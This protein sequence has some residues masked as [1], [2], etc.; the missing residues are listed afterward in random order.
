MKR[1]MIFLSIALVVLV[2]SIYSSKDAE[3]G[4]ILGQVVI[5]GITSD[6]DTITVSLPM[7]FINGG[8]IVGLDSLFAAWA[9]LDTV[10]VD[11]LWIRDNAY[12]GGFLDV[13]SITAR[14]ILTDTLIVTKFFHD[15]GVA[16]L[17]T[18]LALP[19]YTSLDTLYLNDG[20]NGYIWSVIEKTTKSVLGGLDTTLHLTVNKST[21]QDTMWFNGGVIELPEGTTRVGTGA[22]D[23]VVFGGRVAVGDSVTR[24]IMQVG[25]HDDQFEGTFALHADFDSD[26]SDTTHG[27][28]AIVPVTNAT[29]ASA[30]WKIYTVEG[31]GRIYVD[32]DIY[33]NN[34]GSDGS[35]SD[36][37]LKYI[38]TV[39]SNVQTQIDNVVAHG[40]STFDKVTTDT[41]VA[42]YI[43]TDTLVAEYT[44]ID[45][46]GNGGG[47]TFLD[48]STVDWATGVFTMG[49]D[50]TDTTIFTGPVGFGIKPKRQVHIANSAFA[51][52]LLED[53]GTSANT[54]KKAIVSQDGELQFAKYTDILAYY[55][56][57]A[58]ANNGN[59]Y[60]GAATAIDTQSPDLIITGDADSDGAAFTTEA[61]T[62]SLTSTPD[63]TD[64][65]WGFTSTQGAGYTFDK[66]V[67]IGGNL[68]LGANNLNLTGSIASTGSRVTKGWFTDLEVTNSI[69]GSVTG[70]A[71]NLSGTPALPDGTTAT[72]QSGSDNSTKI[73]T[74]AYVDAADVAPSGNNNEVLT[75]DGSGGVVSESNFTYDGSKVSIAGDV[76][77]TGSGDVYGANAMD[78]YT[79][80]PGDDILIDPNTGGVGVTTI[81]V[82][83]DNDTLKAFVDVMQVSG[84][85]SGKSPVTLITAASHTIPVDSCKNN[86]WI[87]N[88]ADA[89]DFTLP[90]AAVGLVALF[91]DIGGG[92]ITIDPADGTD[93]IYLDGGSVGA[94]DAIDSSGIIGEYIA[95]LAIDDTRWI[96]L[97]M[98]GTWAD[99]GAD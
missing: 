89:I 85:I 81:G 78:I 54:K 32:D 95:L 75:D 10:S 41:L 27:T 20:T 28:I 87:N 37:E 46:I 93:T 22:Q 44:D 49:G 14:S 97:G 55:V 91:Y 24:Y 26:P 31:T 30:Y 51:M 63:P 34:Y 29:G 47:T 1:F 15:I 79:T 57:M 23:T 42:G 84:V 96:T 65:T 74:T 82:D 5:E 38:N 66:A 80:G 52:L 8:Y 25:K 58:I 53:T 64:A 39:S 61:L 92:T 33:A 2:G 9:S 83:G 43:S 86:I 36:T 6:G 12:I 88:D 56:Q 77:L 19:I 60:I 13:D 7:K 48:V 50:A 62:A 40:D 98:R 90:G 16:L 45:T 67:T 70:T 59:I 68:G 94:G 3:A 99:G 69:A 4:L 21:L 76:Y 35:V 11:S 18:T 73:A 71:T 17:D 72:T